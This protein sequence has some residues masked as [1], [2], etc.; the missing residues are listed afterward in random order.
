VTLAACQLDPGTPEQQAL[1]RQIWLMNYGPQA[2]AAAAAQ[3]EANAA[4]VRAIAIRP[5]AVYQQP[6]S[7]SCITTLIGG[8]ATTSCN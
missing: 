5:P 2:Q 1:A 6:R 7:L 8:I 4:A 3:A